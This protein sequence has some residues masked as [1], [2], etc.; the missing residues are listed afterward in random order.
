[1]TLPY[2]DGVKE[3]LMGSIRKELLC[4]GSGAFYQ[5]NET[6]SSNITAY[7]QRIQTLRDRRQIN[8]CNGCIL[9]GFNFKCANYK[10]TCISQWGNLN[11]ESVF[12]DIK[13]VLL[14]ILRKE[15]YL[16]EMHLNKI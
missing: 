12:D 8:K 3:N 11:T 4:P 10:K 2:T 9:F 13:K 14:F 1:M 5:T 15:S 6:I 16:F 7:G